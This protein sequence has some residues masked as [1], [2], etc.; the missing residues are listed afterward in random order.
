[1]GAITP[2]RAPT[3]PKSSAPRTP[4]PSIDL[5]QILQRLQD[6]GLVAQVAV[7]LGVVD[8]ERHRRC[9]LPVGAGIFR[10]DIAAALHLA[11]GFQVRGVESAII[12]QRHV[13]PRSEGWARTPPLPGALPP[14]DAIV[15][16]FAGD[17]ER[18]RRR[19][20]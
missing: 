19:R 9:L 1:M 8:G 20:K 14:I 7:D 5:Q 11:P 4:P 18:A 16:R 13:T 10:R 2:R 17:Y 15:T 12:L 6:L 3:T